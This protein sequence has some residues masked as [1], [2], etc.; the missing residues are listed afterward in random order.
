MLNI[1]NLNKTLSEIAG[2]Y[3]AVAILFA[4]FLLSHH[5]IDRGILY[6][7][8]NITGALGIVWT[9]LMKKDWQPLILNAFWAIVGISALVKIIF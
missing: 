1:K 7:I 4:Y 2:W 6:Q 5:F 8:L 3:G 9:T